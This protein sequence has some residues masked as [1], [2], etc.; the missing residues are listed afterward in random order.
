[1]GDRRAAREWAVQFLFQR[2]FNLGDLEK[3]LEDFAAIHELTGKA[4]GFALRLVRGA[5]AHL[6]DIDQVLQ[7]Y[8][9]HWDVERMSAVDR[10]V[11]RLALFEM[12]YRPDIPPVVSLNEAVDIAKDFSGRGSGKFVNG[13]LDRALRDLDRPART[14]DHPGQAEDQAW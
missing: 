7:K 13:I 2:D 10:N 8:A 9:E 11:L 14:A 6:D 12:R 1:M 5:I 4:Q 3:D